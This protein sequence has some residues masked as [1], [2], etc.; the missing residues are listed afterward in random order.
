MKI[1]RQNLEEGT[2]N[3]CKRGTVNKNGWGLVY[4]Y[5]KVFTFQGDNGGL[6]VTMCDDCLGELTVVTE[7]IQEN[8][9]QVMA[10]T[11]RRT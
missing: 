7:R 8:E 10:D 6:L 4:P 3:F 9:Y 11:R 1:T 2:C 5:E